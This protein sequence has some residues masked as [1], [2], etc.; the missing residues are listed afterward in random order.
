M[1]HQRSKLSC[2]RCQFRKLR[3]SRTEP[4]SNCASAKQE[5]EYRETAKRRPVSRLYVNGLENRVAWLE[6]LLNRLK[7]ADSSGRDALLAELDLGDHLIPHDGFKTD[8]ERTVEPYSSR[9]TFHFHAE[10]EGLIAYHGPTSIY[11]SFFPPSPSLQS[12]LK[13]SIDHSIPLNAQNFHTQRVA[14]DF[15]IDLQGELITRALR[16][17]RRVAALKGVSKLSV[18]G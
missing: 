7:A 16:R 8:E 6:N 15:G 17:A 2:T 12:P 11:R 14:Q 13:S 5:C 1:S 4:C 18:F 9:T 3:C 10:Y